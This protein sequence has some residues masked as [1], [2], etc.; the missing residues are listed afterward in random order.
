MMAARPTNTQLDDRDEVLLATTITSDL[1][2]PVT[3]AVLYARD[4]GRES[5]AEG[6]SSEKIRPADVEE[7]EAEERESLE[8]QYPDGGYGWVVLGCCMVFAG[9]TMGWGVSWG[10]FQDFYKQNVFPQS[11]TLLSL[12]GGIFGLCLNTVSFVSGRISDRLCRVLYTSAFVSWLAL[13]LA[14]WSTKLWQVILTQGVL[15][16]IGMGMGLPVFF[17]LPSQWFYKKRGL[18]SGLAVGGAGFGACICTLIS[19]QMLVAIGARHTLLVYSFI[20]LVLMITATLLIRT[21]PNS[22]EAR[23][24]GKGPW[25]DPRLR[26]SVPFHL[27]A[28]CLFLNTFGYTNAFFYVTQYTRTVSSPS[29]AILAALPLSLANLCAGIGRTSIG[30]ATDLIGP[31][32][33][34]VIVCFLASVAALSLWLTATSYNAVIAFAVV[35]GLISPTYLSLIPMAAAKVLGSDNLASNVGIC[36]LLTG[37]GAFGG[38]PVG[39]SLL[40]SKGG[41]NALIVYGAAMQAAAGVCVLVCRLLIEKRLFVKV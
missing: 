14:S 22:P 25:I 28:L 8:Y 30:Y 32:N 31:I 16:G 5:T 23:S 37:P 7:R 24:R 26:T 6:G 34:M 38:G 39:G 29:S 3:P 1:D 2:I 36:L 35:Y 21:Q 12:I 18:A 4:E 33:A 40:E 9:L 10:V 41:W 19:R 20:N 15:C 11:N 27:L 17:S 13:F